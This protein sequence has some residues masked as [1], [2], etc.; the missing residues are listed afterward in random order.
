DWLRKL[1]VNFGD[2]E[3]N[4]IT[5][6]GTLL[7][8]LLMMNGKEMGEAIKNTDK[9]T[10]AEAVRRGRSGER[11]IRELFYAALNRPPTPKESADILRAGRKYGDVV[12]FNFY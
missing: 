6:N 3:G 2:D 7:Q 8:A 5:F 10:V 9:G 4:E 11:I 1:V 12:S